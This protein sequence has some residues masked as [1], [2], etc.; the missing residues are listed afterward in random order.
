MGKHSGWSRTVAAA[1]YVLAAT[2]PFFGGCSTKPAQTAGPAPAVPV[3]VATVAQKTVPVQLRVIGRVATLSYVEL[4]AQVTGQIIGV[5]FKPG[6]FVKKGELLFT[7]DKRPFEAALSQAEANLARDIAQAENARIEARRYSQL[8]EQG[9]VPRETSDQRASTADALDAA[10]RADRAAIDAAKL[11]IEYCT[12]TSP[13]DGRTGTLLVY[14]GT[15][16]KANDVPVLVVINQISPTY[17]EF[18]V[19]E[20][21]L[22]A[23]KR[24]MA[25]SQLPVEVAIPDDPKPARGLLTFVDNTVDRATGTIRLRATFENEDA[26]LWPAQFVNVTLTL[27]EQ[28]DAIVVSSQAVQTGQG[29]Q[30]VF[31]VKP[32]ST[33]EM[34]PVVVARS[35]DGQAVIEKG[36]QAGE[37]VVTD[38]QVALV[39]NAK[40]TIKNRQ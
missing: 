10:V 7:I 13:M 20:Q 15:L 5:Q 33:A 30:Y 16:V 28:K 36:L 39:P 27:D 8:A 1:A 24:R 25:T 9:I 37:T 21:N 29:G 14:P 12:I 26:R 34:R 18:S 19:P 32:D 35:T 17:V 23:I 31:V 22:A 40:V 3:T 11:N 38:G 4:K 6:Q 2:L